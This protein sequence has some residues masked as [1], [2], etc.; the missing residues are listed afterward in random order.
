MTCG[1]RVGEFV[2][3]VNGDGADQTD[4]VGLGRRQV[5]QQGVVDV[6]ALVAELLHGEA[7]V[8]GGPGGPA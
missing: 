1:G 7:G 3:D 4:V 5:R 8:F 6:P 2:V